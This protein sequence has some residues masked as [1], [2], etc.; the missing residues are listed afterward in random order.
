MV[1]FINGASDRAEY[2]KF[3]LRN[4]KNDDT[5]NMREVIER[6]LKH[7]EWVYP[8]LVILDGGEGQINAVKDLLNE[9]GIPV[10]GRNKSGDHTRNAKVVI[11]IP[12]ATGI[13]EVEV[14]PNSHVAKL[15]ARIDEESHRFAITYHRLLKRKSMLK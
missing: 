12:T 2:R 15:I 13:E 10:I 5:G 1:V 6:R 14:N 3:K 9:K 11:V 7:D 8:E 4:Q